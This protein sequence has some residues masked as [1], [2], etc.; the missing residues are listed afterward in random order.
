MQKIE[1]QQARNSLV[2][3]YAYRPL[4]VAVETATVNLIEWMITEHGFTP[5]EAYCLTSTCPDFRINVYQMYKL[6]KLNFVVGAEI[7][8]RYLP[9]NGKD[10]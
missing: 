3:V 9:F 10:L 7:G 1:R 5:V 2:S 6:A 8:K 4:E